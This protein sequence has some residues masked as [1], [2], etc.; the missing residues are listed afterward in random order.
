MKNVFTLFCD[1]IYPMLNCV[2]L[3]FSL[4]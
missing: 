2:P 1:G 4:N 3:L